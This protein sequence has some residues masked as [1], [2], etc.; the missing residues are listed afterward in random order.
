MIE[1]LFL[2]TVVSLVGGA[3]ATAIAWRAVQ[4]NRR[5][6]Q[7]RV[8]RLSEALYAA[9][10]AD[11]PPVAALHLFDR[12]HDAGDR[13]RRLT[14][15][16]GAIAFGAMAIAVVVRLAGTSGSAPEAA[17]AGDASRA[18]ALA[19]PPPQGPAGN[20]ARAPAVLDLVSLVH[21]RTS[22]GELDLRGEV[23][24]PQKGATLEG[25]TA[26]AMVFDRQGAYLASGRAPLDVRA[27]SSS[28]AATFVISVPDATAAG[29]YRVSFRTRDRVI[30]HTDRRADREVSK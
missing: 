28:G 7:A 15:I 4:E 8:A 20:P 13:Q 27:A 9:E 18:Q 29:S 1:L 16:G 30:P 2:I 5:R 6:S 12:L 14:T 24:K 21:E 26:V 25:V 10:P 11:A 17:A 19:G 22:S 3:V 23:H